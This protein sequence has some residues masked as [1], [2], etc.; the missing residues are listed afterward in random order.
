MLYGVFT[1]AAIGLA[2][3]LYGL[4][5]ERKKKANVNYKPVCDISDRISCSK[6]MMSP[7]GKLFGISN[8]YLGMVAYVAMMVL[9]VLN[10]QQLALYGA[11]M[12]VLA[13]LFLAYILFA[14]IKT[15]CLIC[16]SIYAVNL[17]LLICAFLGI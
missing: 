4:W 1:A 13:S 6:T 3:S 8:V 15:V 10:L 11:V 5:V 12:L 16:I 14:K 9:A 17:A 7:W 2:I